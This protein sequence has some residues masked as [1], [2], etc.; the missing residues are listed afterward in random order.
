VTG[1][2]GTERQQLELA[3]AAQEGLRGVVPDEVIDAAVEALRQRL[4]SSPSDSE[5]RRQ[6]TVLFADMSGF[7]SMSERLDAEIVASIMNELWAR[8]DRVITDLGGQIDKHIGDAVMAVWGVAST[9]EDDPERA[10]RAGLA[11]Q[12]E[13]VRRGADGVAMRVGINTGPVHLGAIGATGEFTAMGDTVNVASRVEGIAPPGGVLV[14]HDTYRHIR[15]VFDV[16]PVPAASV[17]GKEEPLRLY[18]VRRVKERRFRMPTRGVEGV[19]THMIGRSRELDVLRVEFERV[20]AHAATRRVTIIGDAGVGKSRLLYELDNWIE[21]HPVSAYFF[22]GRAMATRRSAALGL[23]RD[24]LG[25]RFGVLDSDS[26][27]DVAA[28]LRRGLGPTLDTDEA[29][30]VGHWLGF[31][32]RSSAAVR[33]LL[34]SGQLASAAR[35]HLFRYFESLASEGPVVVFLEDLHWA[36][37]ESLA[38]VD[39]LVAH[40]S[41]AHLLVVGVGRPTLLERPE[42]EDLLDRSEVALVLEPL[43]VGATRELVGEVLQQAGHIPDELMDLILARA[44]GNAFYVEELVKMLIEDGVIETGEAW[45][46]WHIHVDRLDPARV[47]PTLTGVLQ[48][49]LDSLTTTDRIALQRA[50]V[51]GR[52]FWDGA[53]DAIGREDLDA[54]ATS[55]ELARRRELVFRNAQ[56]SFDETVEYTFKHALL[57]DVTYETV[58]LRDRR[59]LHGLVA[60]WVHDHAGE[61]ASE[62]S[63]LIALHLRLA[64]ELAA[65]AELLR[66]AAAT[67]LEVGNSPAARRNLEEALEL[68]RAVGQ[69]PPVNALTT[70]AD[71]C[72]RLGDID[73]AYRYDEQ[74]LHGPATPDE[75]ALA[76]F[77]GSWIAS[78]QG[79]RE[80]ERALLDEAMPDAE[81][82]GGVL[83]VRV[84]NG[85]TCSDMVRGDLEAAKAGA[86]RARILA[87]ELQH[88]IYSR[89]VLG[90]FGGIAALDGD[91][92]GS[93][94]YSADALALCVETGDLEGEALA[95]SNLGIGH[96]LLGDADGS[97]DEYLAA[98]EHY[99]QA[100]SLNRRLGKPL[101]DGVTAANIAQIH[102]RLGDDAAARRLLHEGIIAVRRSGGNATLLFCLLAEADRLLTRGD[103]SQGLELIGLVRSHPARTK[104][105]EDEIGRILGRVGLSPDVDRPELS[106]RAGQDLIEAVDQLVQQLEIDMDA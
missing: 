71:A 91:L 23:V 49:R 37:E 30:L 35:A 29:D 34:G 87:D 54:T 45:D 69:E 62:F 33:Q 105:N 9:Q 40:C 44:D 60:Q 41:D 61:R 50:S 103:E 31:D 106:A 97:T 22:K 88:P 4:A 76:L 12:E 79:D 48:S 67:S 7:T 59:R 65:A 63:S 86:E 5:R 36:D 10:V 95:H 57:R 21:L 14:T 24:V 70:I 32:L 16:E 83:L 77:I 13:L 74:A 27:T 104:D 8:L 28:K 66:R 1:S 39:Q 47:P 78:E 98:L 94:A 100:R 17:K 68:W 3:I 18:L 46:A 25:E 72:A 85:L 99:R 43:G 58:L 82:L 96:H 15:G 84:L 38:L 55:L 56:S 19:E 73:A 20:V 51:I 52:V 90:L 102:I 42:A 80:R 6:V 26:T 11:I 53:V 93:L 75:R 64:G 92:R 81:R 89:E 2:A 101:Q